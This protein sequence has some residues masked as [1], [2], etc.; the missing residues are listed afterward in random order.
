[1]S[2]VIEMYIPDNYDAFVENE[3]KVGKAYDEYI[4]SLP[5]CSECGETIHDDVCY[6][7]F[8]ELFCTECIE[9]MAV[10]T[11]EHRRLR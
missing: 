1:M 3:A 6:K 7:I 2:K 11:A 9:D 4:E 5:V 10:N 8:G